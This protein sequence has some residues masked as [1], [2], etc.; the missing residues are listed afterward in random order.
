MIL[1][2]KI[3]FTR[4]ILKGQLNSGFLLVGLGILL[5]IAHL[6]FGDFKQISLKSLGV[7][8]IGAGIFMI[9]FYFKQKT[10]Q[11]LTI[12]DGKLVKHSFIPK[13]IKLEDIQSIQQ[14]AGDY[15]IKGNNK[16]IVIDTSAIAPESLLTLRNELQKLGFLKK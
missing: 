6:I 12:K 13:K 15:I 7:G 1:K 5:I 11:Y 3:K 10:K 4:Q 2:M 8:Q 16:E 14:F 9:L